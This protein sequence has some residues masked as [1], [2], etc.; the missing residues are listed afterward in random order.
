MIL[1]FG[2]SVLRV[3]KRGPEAREQGLLC[4]HLGPSVAP[5]IFRFH[6]DGYEMEILEQP[7]SRGL[8]QLHFVMELLEKSVWGGACYQDWMYGW[9]DPLREWSKTAPWTRDA[10]DAMYSTE[11]SYG[12]SL[13]HGDPTLANLMV[14]DDRYVITDPMPRL[15]Y[16]KEI[17]NR[18]EVDV[19]KLMQSAAGWEYM[20]GC[21]G[22]MFGQHG[23]VMRRFPQYT[24]GG[25]LWCAIHL[26][27]VALRAP[28]KK[29]MDIAI[30]AEET[31]SAM[32]EEFWR[33]SK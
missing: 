30:W 32:I 28:R 7:P 17:P 15:E 11:P 14:R 24:R 18:I 13:I 4:D 19:G 31:S 23:V 25:L 21:E 2:D 26:A 1:G 8:I 20:L 5:K 33:V 16:R 29:R 6:D 22:G 10:I 9:L 27:R 3:I 12:Y